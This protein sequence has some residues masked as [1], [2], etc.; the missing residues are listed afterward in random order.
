MYNQL[1]IILPFYNNEAHLK[2][3]LESLINQTNQH[4]ELILV[5]D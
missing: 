5:N 3:C 4:F 2:Q 1:T